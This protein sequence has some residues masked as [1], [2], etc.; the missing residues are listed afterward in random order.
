LL[1]EAFTK[2]K[3]T[4]GREFKYG[5]GWRLN[6]PDGKNVVYH[7]GLWNGFTSSLKRYVDDKMTIILLNNTNAPVGSIEKQV[8]NV[9]KKELVNETDLATKNEQDMH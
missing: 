5:Y 1:Q 3:T 7:N 6:E 8:Y 4:R 2:G 9:L